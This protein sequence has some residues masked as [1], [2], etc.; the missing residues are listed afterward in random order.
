MHVDARASASA[1]I[2]YPMMLPV[3][4]TCLVHLSALKL[5]YNIFNK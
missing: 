1:N 4:V 3:A 5:F 2:C